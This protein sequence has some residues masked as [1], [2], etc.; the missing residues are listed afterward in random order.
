[1]PKSRILTLIKFCM[2]SRK[3]KHYKSPVE[4]SVEVLVPFHDV[5][6]VHIAWHGH[7]VKY[8]EIARSAVLKQA[9]YGYQDFIESG[10]IWPIVDLQLRYSR[11]ARFDQRLKVF[12]QLIEWEHRMVFRY[13]ITDAENGEK[14]T[15]GKTVQVAVRRVDG[16]MLLETPRVVIEQLGLVGVEPLR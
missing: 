14:I 1:M 5:D 4:G 13:E 3:A 12:A 8:L 9:G 2:K 6:S 7:Y 15:S 11:P 16:E 10:I